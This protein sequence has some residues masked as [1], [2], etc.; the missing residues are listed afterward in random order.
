MDHEA[1]TRKT[2]YMSV[3]GNRGSTQI[4]SARPGT[5][6]EISLI[7]P[8]TLNYQSNPNKPM[9]APTQF[10]PSQVKA[11]FLKNVTNA[12]KQ[13]NA[14]DEME[15][16]VYHG[17]GARGLRDSNQR[18]GG[19]SMMSPGNVTWQ[20]STG[21]LTIT[22]KEFAQ[23]MTTSFSPEADKD[24]PRSFQ[25]DSCWLGDKR[26][27]NSSSFV[28]D[29]T[30]HLQKKGFSNFTVEG[31][32]T[33]LNTTGKPE[34]ASSGGRFGNKGTTLRD[35]AVGIKT[36]LPP[37]PSGI[38]SLPSRVVDHPTKAGKSMDLR[39]SQHV[40]SRVALASLGTVMAGTEATRTAT[41]VNRAAG[42]IQNAFR[43]WK[44]K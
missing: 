15:S 18:P 42:T 39:V 31:S 33:Q 24:K 36:E 34:Y 12:L 43:A 13:D 38:P 4:N 40:P 37:L 5:T 44:A 35:V 32:R 30:S 19:A 28:S 23:A 9:Q 11:K 17:H 16:F 20:K 8:E 6:Q 26:G 27:K 25:F 2:I 21:P 1:S 41:T 7:R 10:P 3:E 29:F 14:A 22:G